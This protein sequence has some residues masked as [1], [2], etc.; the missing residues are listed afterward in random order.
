MSI[1]LY[2]HPFSRAATVIWMLEELEVPY[3]LRSIPMQAR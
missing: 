1:V 2:H 3:E